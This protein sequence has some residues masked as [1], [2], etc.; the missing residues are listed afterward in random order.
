MKKID[1]REI[2][3]ARMAQLF[4]TFATFCETCGVYA[5]FCLAKAIDSGE[6]SE[7]DGAARWLPVIQE[8][9][10]SKWQEFG[11]D[12]G[13]YGARCPIGK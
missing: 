11:S 6:R 8:R 4:G 9:C 7:V 10:I 13:L 12:C 5:R 2:I 1:E 3:F